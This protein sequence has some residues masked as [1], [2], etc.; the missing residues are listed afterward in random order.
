MAVAFRRPV[1]RVRKGRAPVKLR[2]AGTAANRCIG[3]LVLRAGG[4]AQKTVYSIARGKTVVVRLRLRRKLLRKVAIARRHNR[5]VQ[6]R[7]FSRTAQTSGSP[8]FG[9]R[10]IRLK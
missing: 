1:S 6:A 4:T 10:L 7:L 9:R 3:A 8:V 2:C 5:A